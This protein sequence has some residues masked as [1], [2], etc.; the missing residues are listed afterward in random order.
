MS[1]TWPGDRNPLSRKK[2][3]EKKSPQPFIAFSR[4]ITG[5]A[6]LET[7][8]DKCTV[9][10][11]FLYIIFSEHTPFYTLPRSKVFSIV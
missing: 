7:Q 10:L 1:G 5:I 2:L 4:E 11:L 8:Q 9:G 3:K 6:H